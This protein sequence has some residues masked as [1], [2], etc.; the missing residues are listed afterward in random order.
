MNRSFLDDNKKTVVPLFSIN[1]WCNW[2]FAMTWRAFRLIQFE[3]IN[4]ELIHVNGSISY[5]RVDAFLFSLI[6]CSR[7][8]NSCRC[9]Q[10][11]LTSIKCPNVQNLPLNRRFWHHLRYIMSNDQIFYSEQCEFFFLENKRWK[12]SVQN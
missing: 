8:I 12:M 7:T 3:C 6:F 5:V 1:L 4:M 2:S 10:R 9:F 11:N